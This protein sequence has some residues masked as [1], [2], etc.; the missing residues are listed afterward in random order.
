MIDWF[1]Q[2]GKTEGSGRKEAKQE[3]KET[4]LLSQGKITRS[5]RRM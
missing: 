5:G 3:K 2:R 4:I 1:Q